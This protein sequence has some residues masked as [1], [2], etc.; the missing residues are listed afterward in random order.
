MSA[1]PKYP[2][3]G[4]LYEYTGAKEIEMPK[5]TLLKNQSQVEWV[6]NEVEN[7][8]ELA[9]KLITRKVYE[10]KTTTAEK[11][12]FLNRAIS[13]LKP[14]ISKIEK[15]IDAIKDKPEPPRPAGGAGRAEPDPYDAGLGYKGNIHMSPSAIIADPADI[16]RRYL[17][18]TLELI[19]HR[20]AQDIRILEAIDKALKHN[21]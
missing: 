17:K 16:D 10:G 8:P 13:N 18:E 14:F 5:Q 1:R 19:E 4:K 7:Y 9:R 15:K 6:L 21:P 11:N 3:P 2:V 20:T 12:D